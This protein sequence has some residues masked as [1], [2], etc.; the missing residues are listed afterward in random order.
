MDESQHSQTK[1][2]EMQMTQIGTEKQSAFC[3]RRERR[4]KR[5]SD[6]QG[7]MHKRV[8]IARVLAHTKLVLFHATHSFE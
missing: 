1:N 4:K 7:N 2:N 8:E 6:K 5:N 3:E